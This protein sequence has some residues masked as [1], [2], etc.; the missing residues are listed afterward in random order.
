MLLNQSDYLS[1]NTFFGLSLCNLCFCN[2]QGL[3]APRLGEADRRGEAK[4]ADCL[5]TFLLDVQMTR[6]TRKS[7][8]RF[9]SSSDLEIQ[10]GEN[11]SRLRLT[12]LSNTW[13]LYLPLS[14]VPSNIDWLIP[15]IWKYT[16][17]QLEN[18][19]CNMQLSLLFVYQGTP[20]KSRHTCI[21]TTKSWNSKLSWCFSPTSTLDTFSH[22]WK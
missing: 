5:K 20:K 13:I 12:T 10:E 19:D 15:L 16:I 14:N 2:V 8:S 9:P 21:E 1:G 7:W 11:Y 22:S 4:E 6:I 3:R 18:V 17:H